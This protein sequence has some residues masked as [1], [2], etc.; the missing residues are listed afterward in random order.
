[1]IDTK[2]NY[3]PEFKLI[4][5]ML[6]RYGRFDMPML[7]RLLR[8]KTSTARKLSSAYN[9]YYEQLNGKKAYTVVTVGHFALSTGSRHLEAC[10]DFQPTTIVKMGVSVSSYLQQHL[11]SHISGHGLILNEVIDFSGKLHFISFVECHTARNDR[12]HRT[13]GI[14]DHM[15][16]TIGSIDLFELLEIANLDNLK[17]AKYLIS[18]YAKET[19]V[20]YNKKE[21]VYTKG[22]NWTP[23]VALNEQ[24]INSLLI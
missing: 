16:S 2:L 15:L 20:D 17:Q 23:L 12:Y 3:D 10:D 5:A 14:V 1:M 13:F 9:K 4:E 24:T 21:G 19:D 7:V 11:L 8:S 6:V 22:N 18:L